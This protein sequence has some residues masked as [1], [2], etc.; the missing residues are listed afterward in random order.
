LPYSQRFVD[1]FV[2]ASRLHHLQTRKLTGIP[3]VTHL[4]AVAALVGEYGGNE[5]Q[6]I[7]ALLHDVVE[8]QGGLQRLDEIRASFGESVAQI[9]MGCTDAHATP[10]PPWR[11]RKQAYIDHLAHAPA[12]TLLVS[13]A[14]KLHNSRCIVEDLRSAG[15]R[16]FDRFTGGREGTIWYYKSLVSAFVNRGRSPLVNEL[17]RVVEEMVRLDQDIASKD[18]DPVMANRGTM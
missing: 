6:V 18:D 7:A 10:K 9:V 11:E 12:E 3:Y 5:D 2:Y 15:R 8:D 14:D 1:A 16:C 4:M 17:D 13:A